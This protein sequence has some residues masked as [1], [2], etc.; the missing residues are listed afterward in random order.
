V[1][2]VAARVGHAPAILIDCADL[3]EK[4]NALKEAEALYTQVIDPEDWASHYRYQAGFYIRRGRYAEAEEDLAHAAEEEPW[5][6]DTHG[7][8]GQLML[9][10]GQFAKARPA[11]EQAARRD[12]HNVVWQ[13]GIAFAYLGL[14]QTKESMAALE[15]ALGR[16]ELHED[17]E[18]ALQLLALLERARPELPDI[19]IARERILAR[20]ALLDQLAAQ[21][22]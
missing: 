21:G 1:R 6:P 7:L 10:Q 2:Q 4:L 9:A 15:E 13:Y 22:D 12:P 3:L 17:V 5:H 11:F 18:E 16:T 20:K 8:Q 19:A 14:G